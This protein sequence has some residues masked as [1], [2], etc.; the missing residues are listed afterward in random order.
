[1]DKIISIV[2]PMYNEQRYIARCLN[3][4]L[5]QTFRD[6]EVILIDDGS[7]DSTI[8]I[9]EWYKDKLKLSILHQKHWGPGRARNRWAKVAKGD[10]IIFVD[11]DMYFDKKLVEEL[12][13]P[14]VNGEELG[15]SH[16]YEYVGN[17]ENPISTAFWSIRW[18]YDPQNN[19]SGIFRA[20]LKSKFIERWWF[21]VSKWYG[22]DNLTSHWTW[23]MVPEAIIY[24]NNPESFKEIF[25]HSIRVWA[26]LYNKEQLKYYFGKYI[27]LVIF[28]IIVLVTCIS[29]LIHLKE[30]KYI[31]ILI[32]LMSVWFIIAKTIERAIKEKKISH[33]FYIPIV[34]TL[35]CI[36]YTIW[37][38]RFLFFK[39]IY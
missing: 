9:A 22:D 13:R 7:K 11:A 10:I 14:I 32:L 35:R 18:L 34:M 24:H 26:S 36:W 19:R 6:F 31:P 5:V 38:M 8:S 27:Y 39:K 21:D 16:G 37:G 1:M 17:L 15:T 23:L 30:Y 25:K 29:F 33:L 20:I 12:I 3:S 4:L 28:L 2:I